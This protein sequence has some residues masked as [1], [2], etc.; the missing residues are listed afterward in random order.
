MTAR[1]RFKVLLVL[2]GLSLVGLSVSSHYSVTGSVG[3][4]NFEIATMLTPAGLVNNFFVVEDHYLKPY[5]FTAAKTHHVLWQE[6]AMLVSF[7]IFVISSVLLLA[8]LRR[9]TDG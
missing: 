9:E 4:V 8:H 3:Q 7:L 1:S 2:W 6:P 5:Y